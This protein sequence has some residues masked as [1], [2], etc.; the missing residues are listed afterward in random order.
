MNSY[1]E[2]VVQ[3]EDFEKIKEEFNFECQMCG[4]CCS[5]LQEVWLEPYDIF[6]LGRFGFEKPVSTNFLF[7]NEFLEIVFDEKLKLP[8]CKI[9]FKDELCPFLE[10]IENYKFG[11]K[12]HKTKGKPFVCQL[13][14]IA[15]TFDE[16][17][18]EKFY[19]V[20]PDENCLGMKSETKQGLNLWLENLKNERILEHSKEFYK[21]LEKLSFQCGTVENLEERLYNFDEK[22]RRMEDDFGEIWIEIKNGLTTFH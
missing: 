18:N 12:L 16:S 19:L 2:T 7:E 17:F 3:L 6:R 5:G 11:C 13:S 15:R 21:L 1:S 10:K 14:P 22:L 20:A 8:F 9:K 4:L